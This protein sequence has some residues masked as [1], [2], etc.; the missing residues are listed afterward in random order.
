MKERPRR[1]ADFQMLVSMAI[2]NCTLSDLV[3]ASSRR[4]V[5]NLG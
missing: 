2:E 4:F 1:I 5:E 3:D